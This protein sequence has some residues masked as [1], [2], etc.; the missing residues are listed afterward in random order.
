M[1][2]ESSLF[3]IDHHGEEISSSKFLVVLD[4]AV[5]HAYNRENRSRVALDP[6]AQ[7]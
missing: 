6:T 2:Y 1:L 4:D 7:Q 3:N 5:H